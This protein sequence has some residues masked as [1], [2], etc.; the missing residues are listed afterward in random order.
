M[1]GFVDFVFNG[2]ISY[3]GVLYIPNARPFQTTSGQTAFDKNMPLPQTRNHKLECQEK[4][5]FLEV[6]MCIVQKYFWMRQ[7]SILKLYDA[8]YC[9]YY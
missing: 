6:I 2:E 5:F 4:S 9:V 8:P 7:Y 1:L 3:V